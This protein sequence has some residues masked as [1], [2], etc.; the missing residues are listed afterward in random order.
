MPAH[1]EQTS[2]D[3]ISQYHSDC[4][5][6]PF[7]LSSYIYIISIRASGPL[8]GPFSSYVYR[9]T[10]C[11][12]Y[13]NQ[14]TPW[15]EWVINEWSNQIMKLLTVMANLTTWVISTTR[16]NNEWEWVRPR[17]HCWLSPSSSAER[18]TTHQLTLDRIQ[19]STASL[20]IGPKHDFNG[21]IYS[22]LE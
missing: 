14:I 1:A 17:T 10:V 21:G 13:K 12:W 2:H 6:V 20:L 9:S 16:I 22:Q 19:P 4:A 3:Y 15:V 8:H 7:G 11:S 18:P 5:N